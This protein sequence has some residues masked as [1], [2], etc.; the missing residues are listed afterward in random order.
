MT[1][2]SI[3]LNNL[4]SFWTVIGLYTVLLAGVSA[5][6]AKFIKNTDD[7]FVGSR[8]TPWWVSGLS[9]F[10][11]AFSAS[12]FVGRASFSYNYGGLSLV[13][14]LFGMPTF[15]FGYFIFARKW[16]R[17]GCSTAI[18]FVN[19]RFS[20]AT[21]KFFIWTGIPVRVLDNANRLYV[22]AVLLEVLFG[23]NIWMSIIVTAAI[24]V[25]YT[26][27]GGFLAVV[28]TDAL[29]AIVMAVIVTVVAIAG[30][31]KV[32]GISGFVEQLPTSFYEMNPAGSDYSLLFIILVGFS[33]ILS[34]NGYWS[35]VQRYVSVEKEVDARKVAMSTGISYFMLFPLLTLPPVF[36]SILIP[37]LEGAETEHCFIMLSDMILPT[38]LFSL[39]CFSL[40][41]ATITSLNSELNVLSQIIVQ[42]VLAKWLGKATDKFRLFMSRFFIIVLTIFCVLMASMVRGL[43]G[44]FRYLM[45]LLAITTI[46][47]C[48]P[49]IMGLLYRRTPAWGAMLSFVTGITT[50]VLMS[51]VFKTSSSAM[52]IGNLIATFSVIFITGFI[53][54]ATGQDEMFARLKT[55]NS[56]DPKEQ[57][58]TA[59]TVNIRFIKI[60]AT[61][62]IVLSAVLFLASLL[63]SLDISGLEILTISV[64]LVLGGL[65]LLFVYSYKSRV[66]NLNYEPVKE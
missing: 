61:C 32:G 65:L 11:T 46:P 3:T 14:I 19:K 47:T 36:A 45:I 23:F 29:Q 12:V 8:H 15:F 10:M 28:L 16:H 13:F 9:Y 53:D 66:N 63:S 59:R 37:G 43:G 24:A 40:F 4:S 57:T 51:F 21:A 1:T 31:I 42:D 35:L 52:I 38:T 50:A 22:T 17:T 64:L 48:G 54:P 55:P 60:V 25:L 2:A 58:T 56:G 44:S 62:L 6:F 41:G 30:F 39:L 49:L 18:E 33:G 7:F 34:W 5:Y 26:I 27:A 20:P